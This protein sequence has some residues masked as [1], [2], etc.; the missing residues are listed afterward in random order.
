MGLRLK[1]EGNESIQL[2]ETIVTGVKYGADIP[3]LV[4]PSRLS[5]R[6]SQRWAARLPT[7][8]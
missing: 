1:I 5:E 7:T 8:Q 3:I 6:F 2:N 4:P